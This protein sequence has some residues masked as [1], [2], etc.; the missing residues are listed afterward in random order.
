METANHSKP[1][2]KWAGGKRQLLPELD[3]RLKAAFDGGGID[4]YVEPFVGGG[5]V[6][7]HVMANYGNAIKRAVINDINAD[8]MTAF[9][10]VRSNPDGLI[11]ALSGL[12]DKYLNMDM[13]GKKAMYLET[14]E[15]FNRKD[16]D[17]TDTAAMFMFLNKTC[18]NGLYRVNK[19][20]KF[21]APFSYSEN[22]NICDTYTLTRASETLQ[23]TVILRTDYKETA[24]SASPN[25][26]FYLDPPYR[27]IS[28]TSA[29]TSYT[30][31]GFDDEE[32]LEL[33]DFCH[34]IHDK[35]AKFI[36]S[37]SDAG[38]GY[39]DELYKDFKI[40]RVQARRSINSKGEK[41]G[42]INELII[43]N[44]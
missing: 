39:F 15:R 19:Q 37:N 10:A 4:T 35:G 3:K 44:F 6:Y 34:R 23:D 26:I 16:D 1:F 13:E 25:T 18:F 36:L 12:Q 2:V 38:D 17:L 33:M 30:P 32:Q 27:P 40:E 29:F 7:F 8:L 24:E 9:T 31:E 20:G 42:K 11:R 41:R 14:R 43:T 5:A 22:P 21:N 28:D